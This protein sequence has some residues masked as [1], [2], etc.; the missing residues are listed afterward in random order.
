MPR[1][2]GKAAR[3]R[4]T[5]A[6]QRLRKTL[7][8]LAAQC[9]PVLRNKIYNFAFSYGFDIKAAEMLA[10]E[11]KIS[12]LRAHQIWVSQDMMH[13]KPAYQNLLSVSSRQTPTA[14]TRPSTPD[15]LPYSIPKVVAGNEPGD[16][17]HRKVPEPLDLSIDS[18]FTHASYIAVVR[19]ALS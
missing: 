6:R 8:K 5:T 9:E 10:L 15:T 3:R 18:S 11:T 12:L 14:L 2:T 7:L 4:R 19:K 1:N 17:G 16:F 13:T